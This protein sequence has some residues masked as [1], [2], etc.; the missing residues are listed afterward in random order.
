VG[1]RPIRIAA[2]TGLVLF[3]IGAI[4]ARIRARVY[5]HIAFPGTYLLLAV[6]SLAVAIVR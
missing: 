4:T 3:F 5:Y 1:V 6:A 2:A